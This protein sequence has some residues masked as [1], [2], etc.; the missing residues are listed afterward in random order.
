MRRS[1]HSDSSQSQLKRKSLIGFLAC[2]LY[3]NIIQHHIIEVSHC[4]WQMSRGCSYYSLRPQNSLLSSYYTQQPVAEQSLKATAPQPQPQTDRLLSSCSSVWQ[5]HL[6]IYMYSRYPQRPRYMSKEN[7]THFGWQITQMK[8][9]KCAPF[10]SC[11]GAASSFLL[12]LP[13][14]SQQR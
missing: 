2:S 1:K 7:A 3:S 13:P 10:I 6:P 12:L 9:T 4:S 11:R 8:C 14:T 5:P